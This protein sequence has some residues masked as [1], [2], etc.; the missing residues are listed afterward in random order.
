MKRIAYYY[1]P[2][3]S[4]YKYSDGHPMR[5]LRIKM[6]NS[7]LSAYNLLDKLLPLYPKKSKDINVD[8][9]VFH[10]D[11]Y[12]DFLKTVTT[13]NYKYF[14]DQL[15]RFNIGPD[16]P[17]FDGIYDYCKVYT[18]GTLACAGSLMNGYADIA[19][20]WSGGLHHAKRCEASGFCYANDIVIG[21]LELLKLYSRVLYVDIDI[22]HGD[23]VEEAFYTSNRVIT[24]SFHKYGN[25]FP[26]T[27][28]LDD[29]GIGR[30]KY[31]S[32]NVPLREGMDDETL[33]T[34]FK[35]VINSIM[36]NYKPKVLVVQCGADSIAGDRLGNFNLSVEGHSACVQYLKGFQLPMVILGEGGYTLKD[37]C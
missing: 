14:A 19:I 29:I 25:F 28:A 16:C 33:A 15:M 1:D 18:C 27:G 26:G 8:L 30:G 21:I 31:Y 5:P 20:N 22:H 35:P 24:C 32:V 10:A 4:L 9:T 36:E 6:T 7:L 34:I 37:G 2:E 23:G 13:E 17:I 3:V 11:E 12:V